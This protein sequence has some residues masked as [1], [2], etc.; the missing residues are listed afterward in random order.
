MYV[1]INLNRVKVKD[2]IL[3]RCSVK[4]LRLG[5]LNQC[6]WVRVPSAIPVWTDAAVSRIG[7]TYQNSA[8]GR[9]GFPHPKGLSWFDSRRSTIIKFGELDY[10]RDASALKR[11]ISEE[12]Q[13]TSKYHAVVVAGR[14]IGR[15]SLV[16]FYVEYV[17]HRAT[18]ST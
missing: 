12:V 8:W 18:F 10:R 1:L 2:L 7:R 11:L 5:F 14:V 3:Y 4:G 13:S 9:N 6:L 15:V 16:I 17:A